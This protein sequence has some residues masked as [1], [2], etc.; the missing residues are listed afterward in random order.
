MRIEPD[1]SQIFLMESGD[2]T[3]AVI[4][5]SGQ[6]HWKFPGLKGNPDLPGQEAIYL[7]GCFDRVHGVGFNLNTLYVD[8]VPSRTENPGHPLIDKTQ[9]ALSEADTS[10]AR[11]IWNL[12]DLDSHHSLLNLV[13]QNNSN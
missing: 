3:D 10:M 4:A 8:P 1:N 12:D 5:I 11:I 2:G 6:N 13:S 7:K 9:R